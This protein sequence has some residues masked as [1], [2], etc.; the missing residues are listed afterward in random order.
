MQR[1]DFVSPKTV[2]AALKAAKGKN[3]KFIAG[4]TNFLPDLRHQHA[5]G[6]GVVIDLMRIDALRGISVKKGTVH[7]GAL[8]TITDLLQS[9]AIGREAPILQGMAKKFA[10]PIIRNRATLAGNLIDGGPAADAVPPLLALKAKVKLSG[11]GGTRTVTLEKFLKG[12]RKTDVKKGEIITEVNFPAPG[13]NHKWGYYKLARRNAMAITVVGAAVV[14]QMK[15]N[16]CQEAGIALGSVAPTPITCPQAEKLLKGKKIDLPLA[17]RAAEACAAAASPI[18]DI[19]A[20]AEY[21]KLMCETLPR[22]LIC[23]ALGIPIDTD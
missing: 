20:S 4:G 10:G 18:D 23:Q 14:L 5:G 8:A 12:Y 2:Q 11:P 7:I 16:I 22:R 19:R 3:Y 17:Q 13:K 1:F 9:A 21:R 15:G 6:P